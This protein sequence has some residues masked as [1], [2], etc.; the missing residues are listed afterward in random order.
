MACRY[1]DDEPGSPWTF[2]LYVDERGSERQREALVVILTGD[3]VERREVPWAWKESHPL[4]WR[5][6]RWRSS[7]PRGEAGSGPRER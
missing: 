1:D 3:W 7:T 4:G 6:A 5:P 2:F